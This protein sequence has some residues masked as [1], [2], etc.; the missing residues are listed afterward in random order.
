MPDGKFLA[1]AG[2]KDAF[3]H[4]QLGGVGPVVANMVREAHGY[5][6]HWAVADYLQRAAPP[7][8]LEGGRGAGLCRGQGRGRAG[9]EGRE[10][11]DAHHRAQVR[12]ARIAG[13][14]A[15]CRSTRWPTRKRKCR[16]TSSPRM[17]SASP[18]PA[19]SYLEPLI[20]G[21]DYPPYKNGLP[22]YV[23]IKGVPVKRKLDDRLQSLTTAA[24]VVPNPVL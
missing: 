20:A 14:S 5:K 2:T 12:E 1:E 15:T 11:G 16:A 9:R 13:P 6:Y 17:A 10:R 21:E 8:R 23:K 19:A 4:A 18:T 3:G 22:D 24:G 7:H